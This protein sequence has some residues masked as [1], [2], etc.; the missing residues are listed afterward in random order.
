MLACGSDALLAA[1]LLE[2]SLNLTVRIALGCRRALVVELFTLRKA[3]FKQLE[4]GYARQSKSQAEPAPNLSGEAFRQDSQ[5][6]CGEAAACAF[7]LGQRSTH[8]RLIRVQVHAVNPRL[9]VANE[10]ERIG[11]LATTL[12]QALDLGASKHQATLK[13]LANLVLM[14][15]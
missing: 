9:T 11:Q 2:S 5:S 3:Q 1:A 15:S 13:G 8:H 4:R 14:T 7:Y 6:A 10:A 12:A